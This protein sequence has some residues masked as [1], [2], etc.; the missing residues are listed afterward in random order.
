MTATEKHSIRRATPADADGILSCLLAAFRAYRERYTPKAFSDTVLD[1]T[2]LGRRLDEMTVFVAVTDAGLVLGTVAC[3]LDAV[4]DGHVRGMAVRPS[5]QGY[6]IAQQLLAWAERALRGQGC[7]RVTLDT[8]ELLERARGFYEKSGYRLS[9]RTSDFYGMKLLEYE[10]ELPP[11]QESAPIAGT[12][13]FRNAY[14]DGR[15]AEAYATLEFAG[16]YH[17]AFRDLPELL[18]RHVTGTRALDFGCGSGRSTRLLKSL[19]FESTGADIAPEMLAIAR[20]RDPGGRYHLLAEGQ[21]GPLAGLTFD[22]VL[23]AFPFDNIPRRELKLRILR[24]L[25][26]LLAPG[27]VLVN[28]VSSPDIYLHEWASFSTQAF[29]EQNRAAACGDVVRIITTDIPDARPVE[30]ILFPEADYRILHGEAGF[31]TLEVHKPL[32]HG[33]E[34]FAWREEVRTAPWHLHVLRPRVI[35]L[36]VGDRTVRREPG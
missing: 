22:L 33:D 21:C 4:R 15:R 17:L 36:E 25:H 8:T 28:L 23:C 29:L 20:E 27:G 31:E 11:L 14:Q 24:D 12:T 18:R 13:I 10:K 19:G 9:G 30:D 2:K 34:A 5:D 16:T 3:K 32:A 35:K 26:G 1:R 6:G 7:T